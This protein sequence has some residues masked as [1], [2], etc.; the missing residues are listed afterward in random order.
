MDGLGNQVAASGVGRQQTIVLERLLV[1]TGGLIN[2]TRVPGGTPM[3][4]Q[5]FLGRA[6]TRLVL[7]DHL[8]E[9]R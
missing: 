2:L 1:R 4:S 6:P 9:M 3:S 8:G 5:A 7:E